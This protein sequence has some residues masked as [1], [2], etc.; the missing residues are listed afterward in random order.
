MSLFW[1]LRQAHQIASS[2]AAAASAE[3]KAARAASKAASVE[4]K[5]DKAL[6]ICEAIWIIMREKLELDDELLEKAVRAVDLQDGKL[7]GKVV[8]EVKTCR[9]CGRKVGRNRAACI[10]CGAEISGSVFG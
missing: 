8:R 10:Y 7:D 5:A 9:S 1:E 4:G 2:G 3:S 6:M